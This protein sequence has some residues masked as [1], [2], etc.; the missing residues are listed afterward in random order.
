M[1]RSTRTD[2]RPSI[3]PA[4]PAPA[5]RIATGPDT[6]TKRVFIVSKPHLDVGFTE[7]AAKV[8][9]DN[10]NWELHEAI[11]Q[12]RRL[13]EMAGGVRFVWTVPSYIVWE[14]LERKRGRGLA[15][16]EAG[17]AEGALAWHAL[18][19]TTHSELMDA[20][21]FEFGLS[22]SRRLDERFGTRT[23]AAKMTDV[24]GHTRGVVPLLAAAGVSFLQVGV[25]HMSATPDV[26][27]V[28]RWRDAESGSE[29][30][31]ALGRG[32][33]NNLQLPGSPDRLEFRFVGDNMEVPSMADILAWHAEVQAAYPQAEVNWA[34]LSDFARTLT[35][36][37]VAALPVVEGELGD[38][39]IHGAGTDPAKV[40]RYRE[41]SRLRRQWLESR[42]L[43][44]A[45]KAYVD[46]SKNLCLTAEHTWGL[47]LGAHLH[48]TENQRNLDFHRVRHRSAFRFCEASWAEQRE[49]AE[50][51]VE[52]LE[53]TP[54]A[55]EAEAALAKLTPRRPDLRGWTPLDPAQKQP[56]ETA[57]LSARL[58]PATGAIASLVD[59]AGG[60][61]CVA[62]GGAL[63]LLRYQTFSAADFQ[64]YSRDYCGAAAATGEGAGFGRPGSR[65]EHAESRWWP[66]ELLHAWRR[67]GSGDG[68]EI[69]CHV[70]F[71]AAAHVEYGAPAEAFLHYCLSAAGAELGV[72]LTWF[73][74]TATRLPEATW[75]TFQPAA[76]HPERWLLHK[77]NRWVSPLSVVSRGNRTLHGIE[78]GVRYD[79]GA[80]RVTIE[81]ADAALVAPGQP[82]LLTFDDDQPDLS[83]GMHFNLHNNLWGTNFPAWYED[84]ALFR[85]GLTFAGAR[86]TKKGGA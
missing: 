74:K 6:R 25:N 28:C 24:P 11:G 76:P 42:R 72:R 57:A 68:L 63:G 84:D 43:L 39:W 62:P 58:D 56:L 13:R 81:S 67:P 33:A 60:A 35:P 12:A 51:A 10:I 71:P 61:E 37:Q 19:F 69:L 75:L 38:T 16:I 34:T 66:A 32:Y 30:V 15:E 65:P 85:F 77:M 83:G 5:S 40:A 17:I 73:D 48:D 4:S 86:K 14:A 27:E 7:S 49:Y 26:P 29:I 8:L 36:E 20:S 80:S 47:A 79:D 53:G 59:R 18:P 54:L 21:L 46:F 44:P 3:R 70:A 9:H 45:S 41:L 23:I 2:A 64:R 78:T 31:L 82:A 50:L 22:L 1:A 52:A 55:D